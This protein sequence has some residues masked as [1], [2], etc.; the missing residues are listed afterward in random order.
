MTAYPGSNATVGGDRGGGVSGRGGFG[1][2]GV[3]R[4]LNS[5]VGKYI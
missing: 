2:C 1:Q 5:L 4:A 3:A